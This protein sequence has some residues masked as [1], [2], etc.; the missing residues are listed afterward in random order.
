MSRQPAAS[1]DTAG[2]HGPSKSL[3]SRSFLLS[4]PSPPVLGARALFRPL[5]GDARGRAERGGGKINN[6]ERK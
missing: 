6:R 2:R 4:R 1:R 5:S 3:R